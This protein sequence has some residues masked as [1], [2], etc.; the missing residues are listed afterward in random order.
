MEPQHGHPHL[1]SKPPTARPRKATMR[2]LTRWMRHLRPGQAMLPIMLALLGACAGS[3]EAM[4]KV[5]DQESPSAG[6]DHTE[7]RDSDEGAGVPEDDA[8]PEDAH[9][10]GAVDAA[11]PTDP[12]EKSAEA[13]TVQAPTACPDPPPTYA[14]IEP[15]IAERCLPCHYGMPGGPWPL[16]SY[17]H[18]VDWTDI[19]RATM[20]T[21]V[22]P[23]RNSGMTMPSAE[24]E[25]ILQWLRCGA[26]E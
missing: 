18:V 14:A 16:T 3:D 12:A 13:C 19:I 23:P 2:T 20:L 9:D 1:R 24:R 6:D 17:T 10:D 26:P 21:C 4:K 22:M 5:M 11:D 25:L 7:D 15:V 8:A